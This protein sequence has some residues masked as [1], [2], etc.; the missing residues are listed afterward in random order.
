MLAVAVISVGLFVGCKEEDKDEFTF[1]NT[2]IECYITDYHTGEPVEGVV[3][4]AYY[5]YSNSH[6]GWFDP[7]P[8]KAEN[9]AISDTNGY[10]R[11][12]IP[13]QGEW[14]NASTRKTVSFNGIRL[15]PR[16]N[17]NYNFENLQLTFT[18]NNLN[19]INKRIDITPKSYGYLK[20]I[21]PVD[22]IEK[23][24]INSW[25]TSTYEVPLFK[26]ELILKKININDKLL[27]FKVPIEKTRFSYG[28]YFLYHFDFVINNTKDTVELI[29]K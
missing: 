7:E 29:V 19:T 15:F 22:Y 8:Y 4:D 5:L 1:Y 23:W 12:K 14:G 27:L 24:A 18:E 26:G 10:Y 16:N 17:N 2:Y 9:V 3:F 25:E 6:G 13:K 28:E 11:I 21:M 20:V